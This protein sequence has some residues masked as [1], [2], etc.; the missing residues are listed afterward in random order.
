VEPGAESEV[1]HLLAH[2]PDDIL[3]PRDARC[4]HDVRKGSVDDPPHDFL[5]LVIGVDLVGESRGDEVEREVVGVTETAGPL[6]TKRGAHAFQLAGG[7]AIVEREDRRDVD[8]DRFRI[9]FLDF[10]LEHLPLLVAHNS[11]CAWSCPP[12][13]PAAAFVERIAWNTPPCDVPPIASFSTGLL[14]DGEPP[15]PQGSKNR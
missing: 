14:H 3:R 15:G 4:D 7:E 1:V 13:G 10:R 2:P 12:A 11:A 5:H 8:R 6:L 9:A